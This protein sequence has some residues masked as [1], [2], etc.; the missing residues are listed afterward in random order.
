MSEHKSTRPPLAR[1]L[2]IHEELKR[3]AH[4]N[5]TT[6]SR[7][8][9]VERKTVLRD[10][11]FMRERLGLPIGNDASEKRYYYTEE[12]EA[13]PTM[14]VSEGE[15][16]SLLVARKALE[17]YRGT[18]FYRQLDGSFN[19][20]AAGM[21]D[22]V[23]FTATTELQTISFASAGVGKADLKVFNALSRGVSRELEVEFD[24]CKPGMSARE[25]RHVQPYHLANR[26]NLWY[27][28]GR[29]RQRAALRTFAVPRI[30]AVEVTRRRFAID[31][32]FSPQEFFRGALGVMGGDQQHRVVIRFSGAAA[33]RV[34]EREWHESQEL[35][36]RPGGEV[37]LELV[38]GALEEVECWVLSWGA[39][40]EVLRP[41]QLRRSVVA[42]LERTRARYGEAEGS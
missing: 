8:L 24:Y 22:K 16:F 13:F 5:C 34:R 29:C 37:D 38:L 12:V 9:E 36:E 32:K 30:S 1:M 14:Q 10:V 25:R 17:P 33:T 39:E 3:G 35:R 4:A 23:S 26:N 41:A 11:K 28:V 6:L 20:L 27:L 31:P 18:S 40:A 15:V 21:Q 2:Q 42:T 19:K 7:L